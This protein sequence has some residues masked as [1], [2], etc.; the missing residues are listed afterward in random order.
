MHTIT[1]YPIGNADCFSSP[2]KRIKYIKYLNY[3][4]HDIQ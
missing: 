2:K 3:T 4:N 1:F